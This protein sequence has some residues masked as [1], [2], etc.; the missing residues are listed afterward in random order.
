M[1]YD[2]VF[3][4]E[5]NNNNNNNNSNNKKTYML[6]DPVLNMHIICCNVNC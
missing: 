3:N 1:S 2:T 5:N 6:P 4:Y